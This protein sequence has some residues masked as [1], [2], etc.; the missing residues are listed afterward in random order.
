MQMQGGRAPSGRVTLALGSKIAPG[1]QAKWYRS[2]VSLL[3]GSSLYFFMPNFSTSFRDLKLSYSTLSISLILILASVRLGAPK[4]SGYKFAT[5]R[6]ASGISVNY[7]SDCKST[8]LNSH[9]DLY[10]LTNFKRSST[11]ESDHVPSLLFLSLRLFTIRKCLTRS[12]AFLL[13]LSLVSDSET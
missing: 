2:G 13:S 8:P 1:L 3:S 10:S 7:Q 12:L 5:H 9:L 6:R 4:S 11:L